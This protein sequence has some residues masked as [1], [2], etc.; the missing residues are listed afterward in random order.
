MTDSPQKGRVPVLTEAQRKYVT[1]VFE[2][3][4]K[5]VAGNPFKIETPYGIPISVGLGD[6]FTERDDLEDEIETLCEKHGIARP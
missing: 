2:C 6:A 5:T 4:L 3:N 1:M